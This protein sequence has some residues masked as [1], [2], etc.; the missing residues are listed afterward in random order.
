VLRD[1]RKSVESIVMCYFFGENRSNEKRKRL[2][3]TPKRGYEDS[4]S[5]PRK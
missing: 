1:N 4:L 5:L 3:C 2:L